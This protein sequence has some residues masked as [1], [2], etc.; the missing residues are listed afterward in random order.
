MNTN[1]RFTKKK[2]A[3]MYGVSYNTFLK[4]LRNI[5]DLPKYSSLNPKQIKSIFEYLGDP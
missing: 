3:A 4:W 1:K 2:L 5:P